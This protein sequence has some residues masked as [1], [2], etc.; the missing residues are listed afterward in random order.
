[1][2]TDLQ[3]ILPYEIK[4]PDNASVSNVLLYILNSPCT[5]QNISQNRFIDSD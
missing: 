1:M 3:V 2:E 4:K 5:E